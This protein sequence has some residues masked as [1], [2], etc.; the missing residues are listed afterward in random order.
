MEEF[1]KAG[2]KKVATSMIELDKTLKAL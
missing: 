2:V 1:K